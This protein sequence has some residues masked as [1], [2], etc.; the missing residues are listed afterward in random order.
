MKISQL[1]EELEAIRA[2]HGDAEVVI[3]YRDGG[4]DYSGFDSDLRLYHSDH[5][6]MVT[7]KCDDGIWRDVDVDSVVVL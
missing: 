5:E 3:Q 2:E 7:T 6:E 4:G 1:I